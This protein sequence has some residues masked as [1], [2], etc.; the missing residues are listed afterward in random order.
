MK[1]NFTAI[2]AAVT[3]AIPIIVTTS[4]LLVLFTLKD[5]RL[6]W[7]L[8]HLASKAIAFSSALTIELSSNVISIGKIA[9]NLTNKLPSVSIPRE[10]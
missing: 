4:A 2:S 5:V 7:Q 8:K 6:Q 10:L 1:M 9:F 3:K